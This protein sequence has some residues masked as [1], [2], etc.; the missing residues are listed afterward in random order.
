MK[1][2][3]QA[4]VN[5]SEYSFLLFS[6]VPIQCWCPHRLR[7]SWA[8]H[9]STGRVH[10]QPVYS[11]SQN[12]IDHSWSGLVDECF[13][14]QMIAQLFPPELNLPTLFVVLMHHILGHP[15]VVHISQPLETFHF[16]CLLL[17]PHLSCCLQRRFSARLIHWN[18]VR[19]TIQFGKWFD[20]RS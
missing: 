7:W 20:D 1:I 4:L 12:W 10:G 19:T 5:H 17:L 13:L 11:L 14:F 3:L 8:R 16:A 15:A 2:V 9:S 18:E 6:R